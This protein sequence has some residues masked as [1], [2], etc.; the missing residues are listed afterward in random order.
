MLEDVLEYGTSYS[1][2]LIEIST[3]AS[4]C[5]VIVHGPVDRFVLL[6]LHSRP[7]L[8]TKS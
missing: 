1:A 7:H 3:V 4:T 6:P 8:Y 2:D 5:I